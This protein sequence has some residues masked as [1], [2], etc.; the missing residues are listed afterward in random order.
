M[1]KEN[2]R[3]KSNENN[4]EKSYEAQII[5]NNI[6]YNIKLNLE[7]YDIVQI[8]KIIISFVMN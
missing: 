8:I 6:I 7:K 5:K 1:G 4:N 2:S 3:V